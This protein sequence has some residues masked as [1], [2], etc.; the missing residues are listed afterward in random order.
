MVDLGFKVAKAHAE[1]KEGHN[2]VIRPDIQAKLMDAIVKNNDVYSNPNV[3]KTA[4]YCEF[5]R[6]WRGL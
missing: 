3:A 6:Q 2:G 1:K 4:V 5:W